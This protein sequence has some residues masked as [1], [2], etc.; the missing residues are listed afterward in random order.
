MEVIVVRAVYV[1][2]LGCAHKTND[3]QCISCD[4][5]Y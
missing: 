2:G 1:I 4:R 5:S 3:C